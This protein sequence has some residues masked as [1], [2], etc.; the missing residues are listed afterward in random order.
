MSLQ[1]CA[2]SD[3]L[4]THIQ[5][6]QQHLKAAH[7]QPIRRSFAIWLRRLL[8][9]KFKAESIPEYQEL[10]EVNAMLAERLTDWTLQWKKEGEEIG[11]KRG[12]KIGEE[13]GQKKEALRLLI[14]LTSL[15]Y[16]ELPDWALQKMEQADIQQLE[17]WSERILTAESLES[18]LA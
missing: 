17:I 5:L 15:K 6:L 16:G 11:E 18:L 9:V 14:K 2:T 7:Y 13:R 1:Q 12:Q 8:R 3:D 10:T 4:Q